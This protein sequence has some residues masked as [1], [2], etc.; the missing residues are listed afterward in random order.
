[1]ETLRKSAQEV[2]IDHLLAEEFKCDSSFAE[3]FM[4]ACCRSCP[5]II[6]TEAIPEPKLCEG[7]GDLLVKGKAGGLNVALLIEDKITA[8][9]PPRQA[10]RYADHAQYMR[11]QDWHR[12]W[13]ILVAPASYRGERSQ[14]DLSIDLEVVAKM[15]QSKEPLRLEYR[16]SIIERALSKKASTDVKNPD[17]KLRDLKFQYLQSASKWC[18]EEGFDLTFPE[19]K[20]GYDSGDSWIDPI[21]CPRLPKHVKMRHRLW[22]GIQQPR[23]SID[24][25]AKPANDS[26]RLSFREKPLA[27]AIAKIFSKDK[28]IQLC[29]S[30]PEL[31]QSIGF[32]AKVA[33]ESFETMR[34]LV[35]WYLTVTV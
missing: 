11:S 32:D 20:N 2:E 13:T 12:V 9:P 4:E 15:L 22:T 5:G 14:Y 17:I 3:R 25:I 29:M 24:L 18:L 30:V 7:F 8:G 19:I 31:R 23:G 1:M 6:V 34:K 33:S 16:R 26:E 27:G 21:G 35:S 28:G 10:Q